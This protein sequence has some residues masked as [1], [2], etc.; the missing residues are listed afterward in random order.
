MAPKTIPVKMELARMASYTYL[1]ARPAGHEAG[2][3]RWIFF[4]EIS[5]SA[6]AFTALRRGLD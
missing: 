6:L 5:P 2:N 1:A 4:I 3:H